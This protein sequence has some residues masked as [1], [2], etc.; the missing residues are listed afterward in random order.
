MAN[1][2]QQAVQK[3]FV[4]EILTNK[5]RPLRPALTHVGLYMGLVF[6]TAVGALVR[7]LSLKH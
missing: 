5:L 1:P 4:E 3:Q 6:Y 7:T 2:L